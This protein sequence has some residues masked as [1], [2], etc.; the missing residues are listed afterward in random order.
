MELEFK[1]N[2]SLISRWNWNSQLKIECN[3]N[4]KIELDLKFKIENSALRINETSVELIV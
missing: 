1:W 2:L 3:F 4:L